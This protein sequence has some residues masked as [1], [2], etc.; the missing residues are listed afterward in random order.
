MPA[1]RSWL[2]IRAQR[3]IEIRDSDEIVSGN[4]LDGKRIVITRAQQQSA[5]LVELLTRTGAVPILVPLVQIVTPS[6]AGA[7]LGAALNNLHRF[8]W[9]VVTSANGAERVR[10]A[11]ESCA[12]RPLVAA[13]GE[14]TN[15]ALGGVADFMPTQANGESL[16]LEFGSG[17]GRVLVAQA[18]QTDGA[19][20]AALRR[21]GW[22]VTE[23]AAY[24]TLALRPEARLLA[25]AS[26]ADAIIFASGS[27]A[28]SWVATSAVSP[29]VVVAIGEKTATVARSVG[30]IVTAVAAEPTPACLLA[31]L[32]DIFSMP[33]P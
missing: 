9:L 28:K 33:C 32:Q 31:T 6:D 7:G 1:R 30:V 13:V 8:D 10:D 26:S 22:Q 18:E 16:A 25:L 2:G 20:G 27:A 4:F 21:S 12:T 17:S 14:A 24:K 29:D 15:I 11:L 19:V 5:V 23:V 3:C